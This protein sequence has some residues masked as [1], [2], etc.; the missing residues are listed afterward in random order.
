MLGGGETCKKLGPAV[1]ILVT[2]GVTSRGPV[3]PHPLHLPLLFS[4]MWAKWFWKSLCSAASHRAPRQGPK[5]SAKNKPFFF[6]NVMSWV[7]VTVTKVDPWSIP[8]WKASTVAWGSSLGRDRTSIASKT[9][10]PV[11]DQIRELRSEWQ[12]KRHSLPF[13]RR[14]DWSQSIIQDSGNN[15]HSTSKFRS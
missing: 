11:S 2:G 9:R 13:L 14:R 6:V 5:E 15:R 7:F 4:Q 1:I 10:L 3:G 12:L 8:H